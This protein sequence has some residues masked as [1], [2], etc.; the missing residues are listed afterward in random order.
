[1]TEQKTSHALSRTQALIYQVLEDGYTH[2]P[3]E[4]MD[5]CDDDMMLTT[6]LNMQITHLR[7]KLERH[8][9]SVLCIHQGRR[10]DKQTKGYRLVRLLVI[11]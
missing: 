7:Q 8:G 2:S 4:L 1:M 6:A 10:S 3:Q 9:L 5:A 11:E